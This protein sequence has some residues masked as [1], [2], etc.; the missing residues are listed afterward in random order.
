MNSHLI[1]G[2]CGVGKSTLLKLLFEVV[3]KNSK[4]KKSYNFIFIPTSFYEGGLGSKVNQLIYDISVDKLKK[5]QILV[6]DDLDLALGASEKDAHALREILIRADSKIALIATAQ[7]SFA[8]RLGYDKAFYGFLSQ[9]ILTEGTDKDLTTLL[10][11]VLGTPPWYKLNEELTLSNPFWVLNIAG[12]NPRL[13]TIL[14]N[15][16]R[17]KWKLI[18]PEDFIITYFEL[19]G[20][21]F[22]NELMDLPRNSRY[23]LE[24]ASWCCQFFRIKD[25]AIDVKNPSREAT[26]LVKLGYLKKSDNGEYSF[27]HRPL[28]AWLRYVKQVPLG[29]IIN[30]DIKAQNSFQF[31]KTL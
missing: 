12:N 24:E 2:D 29:R 17:R 3:E 30:V 26:K 31:A 11:D 20:P 5:H 7:N 9:H 28:K 21:S 14:G 22:K 6:V 10:Q 27:K 13:L 15:V 8:A 18:I 23:F 16:F 25:L 4:L 19:A 1:L